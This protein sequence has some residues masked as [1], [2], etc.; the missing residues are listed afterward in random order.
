[1]NEY[2]VRTV[3]VDELR[4]ALDN[5]EPVVTGRAIVYNSWSEDLGGWREVIQPGAIELEDDLR[6]LFDHDTSMVIG[7]TKSGT[8]TAVDDGMGVV[9]RATPPNTTWAK[10]MLESMKRGD[11]DQM[12]FRMMVLDDDFTYDPV[13]DIVKRTVKRAAVSELSIVSM[14]A[15]AETAATTRSRVQEMREQE[16]PVPEAEAAKDTSNEGEAEAAKPVRPLLADI[17][18]SK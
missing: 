14:P 18:Y 10:D 12:S 3:H 5:D 7:R 8:A 11:I 1:M 6:I 4:A 15:Y 17:G 9:M 13:S 2:E 16:V